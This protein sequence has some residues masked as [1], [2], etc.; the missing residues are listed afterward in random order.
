MFQNYFVATVVTLLSFL[1]ICYKETKATAKPNVVLIISDQWSTRVSD[2]S[3]NYNNGIQTPSIDRLATEGI[4]FTQSYSSYPLCS[5]ARASF[6]TGLYPHNHKV[7][8]N[9]EQYE[10]T[11]SM[12]D[13]G[14]VST[15]GREFKKAG[16]ETAYFG[17]EHAANYGWEGIEKFG[18]MKY[19]SGGMLAEGSAYDQIFTKDAVEFIKQPHD[20][21]FYMTLSLINPHDICKVLGGKVKGATFADAIHFCRDDEELYLRFQQRPGAPSNHN[22]PYIKGMIRDKDYMYEEV[23]NQN[24]NDWKRYISA[25]YLLIEKTDW[26][27]GLVMDALLQ[28]GLEENTIVVFTTDH[29]DMMGSHKLIAKTTFYEESAKTMM[30]IRYPGKIKAGTVDDKSLVG[31][32]D[33]MPT[34]LDM[35]DLNIPENLDGKS[36][37]SRCYGKNGS[38]FSILYS[39]NAN[40]RMVRFGQYKYV[41]SEVYGKEYEILFDLGEDPGET[42]NVFSNPDYNEVS[43]QGRKLLNKWMQKE[44]IGL[45]F[46]N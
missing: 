9:E 46:I 43:M 40:G 14:A 8:K 2:G 42:T 4:R 30:I 32:I 15:L 41:H 3:G 16:Y 45:T 34:L 26:Y 29:G 1:V 33:L 25:Y 21:P 22:S 35:S 38:D 23:L 31:S 37:K 13:P 36:F 6:F 27:I 10:R 12:P 7:V 39:V 44:N 5:P 20:K 18:S 28:S 19:S 24:E 17:K 11:K